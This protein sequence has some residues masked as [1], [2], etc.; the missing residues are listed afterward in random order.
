MYN[1]STHIY[2]CL[3]LIPRFPLSLV[4]GPR[5]IIFGYTCASW[6]SVWHSSGTS[7][8]ES[9]SALTVDPTSLDSPPAVA[10][11]CAQ[12]V[13]LGVPLCLS[14]RW[15]GTVLVRLSAKSNRGMW[16]MYSAD[17]FSQAVKTLTS[18][19]NHLS[20]S[21]AGELILSHQDNLSGHANLACS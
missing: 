10:S 6:N 3:S 12:C 2:G 14:L 15:E 1:M 7:V 17:I 16:W 18:I 4:R 19:R 21:P 8:Q 20:S 9:H 13:D 11:L 5:H